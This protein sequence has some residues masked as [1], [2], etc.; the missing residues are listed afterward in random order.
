MNNKKH[1]Y[2]GKFYD[3]IIA[4]NQ[5]RIFTHIK[6]IIPENSNVLDV[7]CG[8]GRLAFQLSDHC[9][10]IVGIDLSSK[11]ISVAIS[12]KN[13]NHHN[14]KF[15][16]GEAKSVKR[17]IPQK[18]DY[19]V[20]TYVIHEMPESERVKLLLELKEVSE[21]I[22]I[23]DYFVPAPKSFWGGINIVVEYLAG[24]DHYNNFKNFVKNGG[25][26][27]LVKEANLKI[28]NEIKNQPQ[29]SHLVVLE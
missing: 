17:I 16:N 3:K 25:I 1:W 10:E 8:T 15:Y 18:F 27:S 26:Y 19:G 14:V 9:N 24:S 6:N 7:G 13:I 23:G 20:L 12:K 11:N 5:D 4:P 21:K 28:V 22:I 2:D 29:T